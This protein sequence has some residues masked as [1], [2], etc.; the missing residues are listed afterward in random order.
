MNRSHVLMVCS[1]L[2]AATAA[3]WTAGTRAEAQAQAPSPAVV[4]APLPQAEEILKKYRVAIGGEQ[5]IRKHTARSVKG[6][7]EIPAQGM[8]GDLSI[9]AAAPD[10]IRVVVTLPGLGELQR[11]YDGKLGWSI[12]PAIGPRLLEGSELAEFRHSA[13]FYDDL[14]EPKKFKSITVVGRTAFEG[15][16]CYELKLVK[17]SGF[18]YTEFFS[19]ATGLIVGGKLNAS[20]QM[21]SVPV[22]SVAADYKSF[23][24]VL[25]PT[26]TRQRMMGLEQLTTV[27]SVTFDPIDP[28][29]FE[30]PPAIAALAAQKK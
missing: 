7:F 18:E 22:T 25:V 9:I 21:G 30:L 5:A 20:S 27:L 4:A 3:E 19:V 8:K 2:V 29:A 6:T 13:D 24:G 1:V 16:E 11:G 17:D 10:M 28:K 23:G 26:I 12:D 15:Q 14:H